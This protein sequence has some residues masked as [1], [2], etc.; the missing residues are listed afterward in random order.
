[1][2][3]RKQKACLLL[4]AV[5]FL[6]LLCSVALAQTYVF[7]DAGLLTEAEC[8]DLEAEIDGLRTHYQTDFAV[9]TTADAEGKSS[10]LFCADY[11]ESKGLGQ[12]SA[13]D[14][15]LLCIDMDNRKVCLV[16][17]GGMIQVIDDDRKES[18]YDAMYEYVVD[19]EYAMAFSAGLQDVAGYLDE[20]VQGGQFTYDKET[21]AISSIY[22]AEDEALFQAGLETGEFSYDEATGTYYY[23]QNYQPTLGE[24]L[25]R[26]FSPAFTGGA[27]AVSA[28]AGFASSKGVKSSYTR[29]A[30]PQSFAFVP[31]HMLNL[32]DQ[33]DNL[34]RTYTTT[35]II[36][37]NTGGGGG[38]GRSF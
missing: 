26:A 10:E 36:P 25:K 5:L 17:H 24:R 8:A 6:G 27:A 4:V 21:G 12:G 19:G 11:F 38:G 31:Q 37:R 22:Y 15:I 23:N 7:D 2:T 3:Y 28:G 29:K 20:G 30:K 14:G 16:T 32:L 1:M 13:E 18:I 9:V 33:N 35:R 34:V